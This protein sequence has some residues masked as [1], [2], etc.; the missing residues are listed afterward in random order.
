M[1]RTLV[2]EDAAPV[3]VADAL[4][5]G[6]VAVAVLASRVRGTLFAE[7]SLPSRATPASKQTCSAPVVTAHDTIDSAQ[8]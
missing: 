3:G 8:T 7:V 2:A 1:V 6:A 5:G 4:P